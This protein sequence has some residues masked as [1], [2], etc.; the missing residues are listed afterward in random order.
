MKN[1]SNEIRSN[2]IRIRGE[3]PVSFFMKDSKNN[4]II[5]GFSFM[6]LVPV[7]PTKRILMTFLLAYLPSY[8]KV[9]FF[10]VGKLA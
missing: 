7:Y 4:N 2:E 9:Y 1:R 8:G 5:L 6:Y 10:Y 3:L